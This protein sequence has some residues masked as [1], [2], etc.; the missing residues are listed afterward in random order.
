MNEPAYMDHLTFEERNHIYRWK[1]T[2]VPSVT[3]IIPSDY[4]HV[5]PAILARKC[6]IGTA[7]HKAVELYLLRKLDWSTIDPAVEPYL[8]SF[9]KAEQMLDLHVEP[10]DIE[11]MTYHPVYGYATRADLPRCYIRGE[12]C[13]AELKTIA[14]MGPEVQ[15]QTAG[16]QCSEHYRSKALGIELSG[17]RYGLQ[18]QP[19]GR[20]LP[21]HAL[22]Y[23]DPHHLTI[24]LSL[25][26]IF[27]LGGRVSWDTTRGGFHGKNQAI[28]A[29]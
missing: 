7:A 18:L 21:K 25:T 3:Q 9:V 11:R 24:F 15:W 6:Q 13:T 17:P 20:F 14:K 4:S 8:E 1:G 26:H 12:L 27:K 29:A 5:P 19:D 10:N 16:Q 28:A 22:R 23:D 2:I